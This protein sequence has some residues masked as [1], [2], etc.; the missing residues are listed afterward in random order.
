MHLEALHTVGSSWILFM[1]YDLTGQVIDC[2]VITAM[3]TLVKAN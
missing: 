3:S 1:V 2:H